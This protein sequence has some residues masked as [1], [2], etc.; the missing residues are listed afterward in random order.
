MPPPVELTGG[1]LRGWG[2]SQ[3]YDGET[4]CFVTKSFFSL[5]GTSLTIKI[6]K[7]CD[8]KSIF[9]VIYK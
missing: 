6:D 3:S 8:D 1:G 4:A 9:F 2:R 7:G 5:V